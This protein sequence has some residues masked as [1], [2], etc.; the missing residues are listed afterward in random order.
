MKQIEKLK[1]NKK[2]LSKTYHEFKVKIPQT[3]NIRE[4]YEFSCEDLFF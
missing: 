4:S 2:I 3:P 1:K